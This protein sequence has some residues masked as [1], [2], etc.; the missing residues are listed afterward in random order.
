VDPVIPPKAEP[1]PK[2]RVP[3]RRFRYDARHDIV[4][5]PAGKTMRRSAR[6]PHGWFF[7]ARVADCRS[8]A[9]R[10]ECLV[11]PHGARAVVISDGYDALLR[12]RRRRPRWTALEERHYRRHRWR[13]E[14][15][16]AEAKVQHGLWRAVRRGRWNVAIQAYLTATAINLKRLAASLSLLARMGQLGRLHLAVS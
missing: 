8:C 12:A 16:F 2:S 14:G 6:A 13:A 9:L 3:L 7:R 10:G 15:I 11:R 1:P 5:C 4:R